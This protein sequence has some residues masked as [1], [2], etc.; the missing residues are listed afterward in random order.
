MICSMF[1]KNFYNNELSR[2]SHKRYLNYKFCLFHTIRILREDNFK[3]KILDIRDLEEIKR[4]L[5]LC[6]GISRRTNKRCHHIIGIN[7]EHC[8]S[9]KEQEFDNGEPYKIDKFKKLK[10]DYKTLEQKHNELKKKY[11]GIKSSI[12]KRLKSL[13]N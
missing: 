4:D 7:E 3:Y 9:H 8:F 10:N 12:A 6:K 11:N 5:K 13:N 1:V 2:C